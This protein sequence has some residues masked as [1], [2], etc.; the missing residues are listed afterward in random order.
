MFKFVY[1]GNLYHKTLWLRLFRS[2]YFFEINLLHKLDRVSRY[3]HFSLL[4]LT[5]IVYWL[6]RGEDSNF[7]L[8]K[9]NFLELLSE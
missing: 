8:K 4:A 1:D 3:F 7:T 5:Y 6:P 9:N 2:P